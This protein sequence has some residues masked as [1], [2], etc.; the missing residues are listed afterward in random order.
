M[1]NLN[2]GKKRTLITKTR[3]YEW[4]VMPFGLNNATN[5]FSKLMTNI[6]SEWL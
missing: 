3:L 4:L 6:F 2:D 1:M 5:M